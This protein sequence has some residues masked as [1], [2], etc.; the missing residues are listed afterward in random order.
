VSDRERKRHTDA[1]KGAGGAQPNQQER[2]IE[3]CSKGMCTQREREREKEWGTH[4]YMCTHV[5]KR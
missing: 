2:V 3:D 5:R 4:I 1:F